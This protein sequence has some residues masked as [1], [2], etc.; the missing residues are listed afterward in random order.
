LTVLT[1]SDSSKTGQRKA[2]S[3]KSAP[4][5]ARRWWLWLLL[6]AIALGVGW[7]FYGSGEA[8]GPKAH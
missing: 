1:T 3:P 6:A 4:R 2:P 5:K 7:D 8:G